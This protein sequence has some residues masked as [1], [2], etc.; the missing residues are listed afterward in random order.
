MCICIVKLICGEIIFHHTV[1][2]ISSIL[3]MVNGDP[4]NGVLGIMV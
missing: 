1:H 4:L 3:H 2:G